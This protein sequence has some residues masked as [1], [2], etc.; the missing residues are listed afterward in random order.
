MAG[1]HETAVDGRG[2]AGRKASGEAGVVT[3]VWAAAKMGCT[4]ES[5]STVGRNERICVQCRCYGIALSM[6]EG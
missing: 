1:K 2:V 3:G 6:R 5:M 4:L